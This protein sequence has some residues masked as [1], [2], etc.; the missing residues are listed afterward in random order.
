[1]ADAFDTLVKIVGDCS[2]HT[3]GIQS[4]LLKVR[5]PVNWQIVREHLNGLQMRSGVAVGW[6]RYIE[7]H[8]LEKPQGHEDSGELLAVFPDLKAAPP[9]P[10]DSN[11]LPPVDDSLKPES[12]ALKPDSYTRKRGRRHA[13]AELS[14]SQDETS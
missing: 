4:E 2:A 9:P 12:E 13:P 5:D 11:S 14:A 8:H 1:M 6:V 7:R 10:V 3:L